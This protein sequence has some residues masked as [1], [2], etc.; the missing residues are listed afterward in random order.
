MEKGSGGAGPAGTAAELAVGFGLAQQMMQQGFTGGAAAPAV[1]PELL[2]PADAARAL[3][4]SEADV[5]AVLESGE[6]KGKKIGSSWRITRAALNAYLVGVASG[7]R[8]LRARETRRA[9][10]AARRRS[11]IRPSRS[12]SARSAAPSRR[13]RSIATIGKVAERELV[14]GL[15]AIAGSRARWPPINAA[16]CSARAAR[17]SWST[18]RRASGRTASSADRRRC[19]AYEDIKSPI[20]PE[21]VLPFTD[22]SQPR[23]RRHPPLVAQ[24]VA[25]A[26]PAREGGARRHRQE[27]LHSVLDVRCARALPVGCRGRPLLLRQRRG[28]RQQ[29]QPRRPPG[30][31]RAMGARIRRG[32][33]HLRR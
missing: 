1:A 18:T 2:G 5:M 14:G 27:P 15:R 26:G 13:T 7:R 23:A 6:L 3:G 16:A 29:G 20:R 30:A 10:R 17:R 28:P 12:W 9:R 33:S 32:R 11:G 22:R 19:V 31:A 24:Q 8:S 4:V 25:R 21:G